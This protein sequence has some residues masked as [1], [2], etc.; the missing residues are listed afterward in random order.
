MSDYILDIGL[1]SNYL[2]IHHFFNSPQNSNDINGKNTKLTLSHTSSD[3]INKPNVIVSHIKDGI[4]VIHLYTG[5][6][7]C[8]MPLQFS[9]SSNSNDESSERN[10]LYGD[11]NGDGIVERIQSVVGFNSQK[12]NINK[13]NNM[14]SLSEGGSCYAYAISGM[15]P[16]Q[17]L[18]NVSLCS[19]VGGSINSASMLGLSRLFSQV[20]DSTFLDLDSTLRLNL[21]ATNPIILPKYL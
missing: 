21:E 16:S 12:K 13:N 11:I 2:H 8:K 1:P 17:I 18:F 20:I 14:G 9:S 10:V 5:R 15:P 7:L 4:E 6:T 19:G 3:H